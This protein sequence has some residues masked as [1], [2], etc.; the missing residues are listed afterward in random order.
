MAEDLEDTEGGHL[1][2]GGGREAG[3]A[4]IEDGGWEKP[5]GIRAF[6][7]LREERRGEERD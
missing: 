5:P 3:N 1:G 7:A 2:K 4:Q 6:L